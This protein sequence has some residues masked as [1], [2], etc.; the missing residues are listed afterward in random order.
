MNAE[1]ISYLLR[2][3]DCVYQV[4]L[5]YSLTRADVRDLSTDLC[6]FANSA[7]W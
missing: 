3:L 2:E 7:V 1:R 6:K 5:L 4:S